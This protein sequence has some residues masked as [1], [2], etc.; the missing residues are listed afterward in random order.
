MAIYATFKGM[1]L[2]MMVLAGSCGINID[3]A[4]ICNKQRNNMYI[5][6]NPDL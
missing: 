3:R 6:I 2:P 1:W 5:K 4:S